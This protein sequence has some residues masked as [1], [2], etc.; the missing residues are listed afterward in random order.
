[1]AEELV[2][3][4]TELTTPA[5]SVEP[6]SEPAE[7]PAETEEAAEPSIDDDL[8]AIYEKNSRERAPDGRFAKTNPDQSPAEK[9]GEQAQASAIPVPQSWSADV[10]AK[11]AALPSD[12]QQYIAKREQEAHQ[13]ISRRGQQIASLEPLQ[14]VAELGKH[15][16][17]KYGVPI[18]EGVAQLLQANEYLETDAPSAIRDLAREYGVDLRALVGAQQQG[19]SP[20]TEVTALR[21]E[22]SLLK[23]QLNETSNRVTTRERAEYQ[24]QAAT[25][26]S[27][28]ADF[29]KDK[30][31][32]DE[33]QDDILD[34]IVILKQKLPDAAYSD[35]L[36]KAYDHARWANPDSRAKALAAEEAKRL[37]AAKDR[38]TDAK[39][40]APL[41]VKT[42]TAN[43][44]AMKSMDDDLRE[45]ARRH[46]S[47]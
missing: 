22:V 4:E 19:P 14:R 39:R 30:P 10:K 34:Q 8:R 25:V 2:S 47:N 43:S 45:I 20:T 15:T 23:R 38:S 9:D 18:D 44:G 5:E 3:Q 36:N 31:D 27:Q 37:K 40:V 28:I 1:M 6:S 11:W 16:F 29:A 42:S 7:T 12:V 33:L 32:F 24:R 17:D 41:N 26:E 35:I 13:E 21:Q 46:Y